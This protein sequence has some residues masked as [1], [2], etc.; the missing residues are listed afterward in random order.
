MYV[1]EFVYLIVTAD[2]NEGIRNMNQ[3]PQPRFPSRLIL[4]RIV[5]ILTNEKIW[6]M[7]LS[8]VLP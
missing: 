5:L 3:K 6:L 1:F 2:M 8:A 4:H 7:T